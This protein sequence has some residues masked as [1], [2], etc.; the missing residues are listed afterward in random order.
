MKY[1]PNLFYCICCKEWHH[2]RVRQINGLCKECSDLVKKWSEPWKP[3]WALIVFLGVL[4]L[5][6]FAISAGE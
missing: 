1:D 3:S 6:L 2:I 5:T 4:A